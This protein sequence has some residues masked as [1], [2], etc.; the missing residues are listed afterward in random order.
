KSFQKPLLQFDLA[1]NYLA[2]FPTTAET[3]KKTGISS[4]QICRCLDGRIKSTAG[5]QFRFKDDPLLKTFK[6][7][8]D[9]IESIEGIV[10][11]KLGGVLQFDRAGKFIR[12]FETVKAACREVKRDQS[13]LSVCLNG[14]I[15][16]CAGYQWRFA[17]DPEFKDGIKD[18]EPAK[19]NSRDNARLVV[20]MD[21]KGNIIKEYPSINQASR[22]TGTSLT[23]I[24]ECA[25]GTLKKI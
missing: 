22:E 14:K 9:K 5:Y 2:E 15:R 17:G 13:T 25:K 1:G 24:R 18:L 8:T 4:E 23:S 6:K 10:R 7:G 16:T 20:Q 12:Q 3:S 11:E 21:L 19:P